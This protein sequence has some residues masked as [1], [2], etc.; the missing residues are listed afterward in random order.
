MRRRGELIERGL[1]AR[2]AA[3]TS[4]DPGRDL[5]R[6]ATEQDVDLVLLDAP[7]DLLESGTITPQLATLLAGAPADV[8]L[9]LPTEA[10]SR[11]GPVHVPFGGGEHDWAAVE[12]AAWI[13]AALRVPLRLLGTEA[14]S[15]RD[16][17]RLLATAALVVQRAI[18]IAAEPL[19][20]PAGSEGIVGA[21]GEAGLLVLGL[22]DRWRQEGIGPARR[23]IAREVRVPTL[24]VRR[25]LR[26]SGV[27]PRGSLTRFTWSLGR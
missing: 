14:G 26:P 20:V 23:T 6:L 21:A 3:F 4:A 12:V 19:L 17:S 10:A 9:L 16:A 22:S 24:L 25:G 15:E 8:A 5:V 7:A 2:A 1:A 13:A 18:G 11:E 27:A